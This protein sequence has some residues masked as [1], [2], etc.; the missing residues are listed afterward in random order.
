MNT[1]KFM[2]L[3]TI[4]RGIKIMV[5]TKIADTA[6]LRISNTAILFRAVPRFSQNFKSSIH[7]LD[8]GIVLKKLVPNL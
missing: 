3:W 5:F 6:D 1:Y 2:D 7:S 8:L 4:T